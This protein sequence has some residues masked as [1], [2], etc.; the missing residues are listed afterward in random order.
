MASLPPRRL[1][2]AYKPA[3]YSPYPRRNKHKND[4]QDRPLF[5][6]DVVPVDPPTPP[7]ATAKELLKWSIAGLPKDD[8]TSR[9]DLTDLG[10]RQR[11]VFHNIKL[12]RNREVSTLLDC[13]TIALL[14]KKFAPPP[15]ALT[16]A[17]EF[18][19]S[20]IAGIGGFAVNE[21]YA[22]TLI[23]VEHPTTL[24][25]NILVQNFD[26]DGAELYSELFKRVNEKTFASLMALHN[27]FSADSGLRPEEAILRTNAIGI[28]LPAPST[29][30]PAAMGHNGIFLQASRFNHSCSP[31]ATTRFDPASFA[32]MV[33]TLRPIAKGEE[34][35]ISYIDLPAI[36]TRDARRVC[37][38]S[39][40]R[41]LCKCSRCTIPDSMVLVSD[42][43]R[44]R[45]SQCTPA[46]IDAPFAA[47]YAL[48]APRSIKALD[49]V[50]TFHLVF[51]HDIVAEGLAYRYKYYLHL[52]RLAVCYAV[53]SDVR[54]FR[55]WMGKARDVVTGSYYAMEEAQK[56]LEYIMFPETFTPFWEPYLDV[57]LSVVALFSS[58][59]FA[60]D[61][62]SA[63]NTTAITGTWSSGTQRVVPGPGFANPA[64][65][66]FNYPPTSGVGY[67]FSADGWYELARFRYVANGSHP[68][69]IVGTIIWAHGN[70]E[71]LDN[72]SIIL[73]PIGDGYQQVQSPCNQDNNNFLQNYN[74]TELFTSW[75]IFT[76]VTFGPKLHLFQ[77]DGS[78]VAPLF[79]LS[80]EPNMLPKQK[81]R[82][83]ETIVVTTTSDGLITVET[84]QAKREMKAKRHAAQSKRNGWKFWQ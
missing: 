82:N 69:C 54:N 31:N 71:L 25:Q 24:T 79:R 17:I 63:H 22:S 38:Q 34:I 73:T 75:R 23:H 13:A 47:W 59:V 6:K 10:T 81:L 19:R 12:P 58:V 70:Y 84:I 62:T 39:H 26:L 32:L 80:E 27:S 35:T 64:Q 21:I 77:W 41:F 45:I 30:A 3:L 50:I 36:P 29:Y 40:H 60:A 48:P 49:K 2:A 33:T 51:V 20:S 74:I 57:I 53:Q 14:P 67:S 83:N 28:T 18:R 76:D 7:P 44:L 43:R 16:D 65:E 11:L 42:A 78:P 4:R 56:M 8:P 37:L 66:S 15:V 68:E 61:Y 9:V 72:G 52:T 55:L 1:S 5:D 46:Q